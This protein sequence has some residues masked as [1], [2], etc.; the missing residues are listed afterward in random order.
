MPRESSCY[1]LAEHDPEFLTRPDVRGAR[2]QIEYLKADTILS[3]QYTSPASRK[4]VPAD[5]YHLG[6]LRP[7]RLAAGAYLR[8][9]DAFD[10][11]PWPR[12]PFEESRAH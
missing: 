1:R 6:A 2:L 4:S 7:F 5:S 12:R 9:K 8:R 11:A 10:H 3:N